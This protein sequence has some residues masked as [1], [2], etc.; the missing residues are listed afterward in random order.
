MPDPTGR[1][2]ALA[3]LAVLGLIAATA[4]VVLVPPSLAA[5][6]A[7]VVDLGATGALLVA[8]G[9]YRLSFRLFR[10]RREQGDLGLALA[11]G[12]AAGTV[13][14]L[15]LALQLLRLLQPLTLALLAAALL[16]SQALAFARWA[17]VAPGA[18]RRY[19]T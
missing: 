8:I 18:P 6:A 11:H 13:I 1:V 12:V 19:N 7:L 9:V 2:R 15:A 17:A 3:I 16:I 14:A 10:A 5:E 4:L